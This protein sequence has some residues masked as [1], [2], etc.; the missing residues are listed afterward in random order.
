MG[1]NNIEKL[2]DFIG[3]YNS[4]KFTR[5]L[6][7]CYRNQIYLTVEDLI[8]CFCPS[9]Q[10]ESEFFNF[11]QTNENNFFHFD[12]NGSFY[13]DFFSQ[14]DLLKLTDYKFEP[15]FNFK[16]FL[17]Y[18]LITEYGLD[19]DD[20]DIY[21]Y[22]C[23]EFNAK[24]AD[25]NSFCLCPMTTFNFRRLYNKQNNCDFIV[26]IFNFDYTNEGRDFTFFE[27]INF[28]NGKFVTNEIKKII[29]NK[30]NTVFFKNDDTI[31]TIPKKIS[32]R[33]LKDEDLYLTDGI[34]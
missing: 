19:Y 13:T 34:I 12:H 24:T 26:L 30:I 8:K 6:N 33:D 1:K 15:I 17:Y 9:N 31:R 7:K 11:F 21:D 18:R 5:L 32:L 4:K 10:K 29:V 2:E 25:M 28:K 16:G 20:E 22:L 14:L 3:F 27:I 23:N